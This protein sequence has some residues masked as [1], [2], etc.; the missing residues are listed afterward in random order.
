[1]LNHTESSFADTILQGSNIILLLILDCFLLFNCTRYHTKSPRKLE[2]DQ[3]SLNLIPRVYLPK[4]KGKVPESFPQG[5]RGTRLPPNIPR[6]SQPSWY[7]HRLGSLNSSQGY[8]RSLENGLVDFLSLTR[9]NPGLRK[10]LALAIHNLGT[11]SV[12][13]SFNKNANPCIFL[14]GK[15][16]QLPAVGRLTG[17]SKVN[18]T[19]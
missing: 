7:P 13:E 12:A 5:G 6:D 15:M 17:K 18:H 2:A 14:Q 16:P 8:L 10:K 19:C 3:Q 1:M 4:S 11:L 9:G